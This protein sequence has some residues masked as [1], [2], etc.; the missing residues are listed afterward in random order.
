MKWIKLTDKE[1]KFEDHY[2]LLD[3]NKSWFSGFLKEKNEK[4]EGKQYLFRNVENGED[5]MTVTHYMKIE[6]PKN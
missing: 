2:V 5:I 6:L 3:E 1:P 4:I